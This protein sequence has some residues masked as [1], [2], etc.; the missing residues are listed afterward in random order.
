MLELEFHRIIEEF[1]SQYNL[2][3][4]E[5][6]GLLRVEEKYLEKE[7]IKILKND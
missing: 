5:I 6:I 4:L 1:K 2:T 7:K 3:E